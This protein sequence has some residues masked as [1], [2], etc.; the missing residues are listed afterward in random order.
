MVHQQWKVQWKC[1]VLLMP[2]LISCRFLGPTIVNI[3]RL[4]II[5]MYAWWNC[6]SL[7]ETSF[8]LIILLSKKVVVQISGLCLWLFKNLCVWMLG[9]SPLLYEELVKA[10]TLTYCTMRS[11]L[12]IFS[13][14]YCQEC[15]GQRHCSDIVYKHNFVDWFCCTSRMNIYLGTLTAYHMK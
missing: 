13:L 11:N 6:W 7:W 1:K 4:H 12:F 5:V 3:E 14:W 15:I 8:N 9:I 10:I 2:H